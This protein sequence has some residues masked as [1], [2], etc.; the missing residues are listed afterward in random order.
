VSTDVIATFRSAFELQAGVRHYQRRR[1]LMRA[2]FCALV[3][4]F[5]LACS[6]AGTR[7]DYCLRHER[8]I[9]WNV[10]IGRTASIPVYDNVCVERISTEPKPTKERH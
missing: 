1:Q 8:Q 5:V 9:V 10:H 3:V 7:R 2:L 6:Q 4:L